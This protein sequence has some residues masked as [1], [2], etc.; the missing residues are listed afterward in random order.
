MF[1]C[2]DRASCNFG[3]VSLVRILLVLGQVREVSCFGVSEFDNLMLCMLMDLIG[4]YDCFKLNDWFMI[5][6][7][8]CVWVC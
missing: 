1:L 5:F 7:F 3:G 2:L 6:E 8:V 4:V